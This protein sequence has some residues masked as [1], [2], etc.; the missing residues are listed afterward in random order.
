M[1]YMNRIVMVIPFTIKSDS[2]ENLSLQAVRACHF[3]IVNVPV[4]SRKQF[5][6]GKVLFTLCKIS[7]FLPLHH[8]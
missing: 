7:F 6:M 3:L 5:E 4:I 2:P 8:L 1:R